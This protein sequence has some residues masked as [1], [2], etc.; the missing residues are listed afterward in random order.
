[1]VTID[2]SSARRGRKNRSSICTFAIIIVGLCLLVVP[3]LA[4]LLFVNDNIPS[5]SSSTKEHWKYIEPAS[6]TASHLRPKHLEA[7]ISSSTPD[8]YFNGFP[9]HLRKVDS[10]TFTSSH[11]HCI[12]ENF[13][14]DSWM[15]RSCQFTNLCYDIIEKDFVIFQ[16]Y[17]DMVLN[18]F[19]KSRPDLISSSSMYKHDREE[20]ISNID[21]SSSL[22]RNN[23]NT[24]PS[25]TTSVSLG[26]I[27]IKWSLNVKKQPSSGSQQMKWFPRIIQLPNEEEENNEKEGI[28]YY[29]LPS[30]VVMIPYHSLAG[31]NPGHLIWDDFLPLY[32]LLTMFQLQN[33]DLLLLRVLLPEK[34]WSSC[35]A[36]DKNEHMCQK[37]IHKFLPLL[38]GKQ[39]PYN[40]TTTN[41]V[42]FVLAQQQ[43][44]PQSNYIC[45]PK[46]AAGLAPLTDHGIH[47]AH[48]WM[49]KDYERTHNHGRGP[50]LYEFRNFML[51][52]IGIIDTTT[53]LANP[54]PP[55]KIVF[56]L[57]SS[58][59]PSRVLDFEKQI[60][61]LESNFPQELIEIE[62]YTM[63]DLSMEEQ[64]QLASKTSIFITICGGGAV[65]GM[66]LPKGA[67]VFLYYLA[68]GGV[69]HGVMTHLPAQLDW[70]LFNNL[71]Y[72]RVHWLPTATMDQTVDL[73][74]LVLLVRHELQLIQS[75]ALV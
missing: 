71:S 52:N 45:S 24:T 57:S 6:L 5:S 3:F 37:M 2:S 21:S 62:A 73:R 31:M 33:R 28:A 40:T 72:L 43:Q 59:I 46:G 42:Q 63:K 51:S 58:D 44:K 32:T 38:V 23:N 55:Y 30:N 64:M 7:E 35:E 69:E 26:G 50:M 48:G 4:F 13:H 12:G 25:T 9:L 75:Q 68:H 66:F 15:Q 41:N 16:S 22:N 54:N 49:R 39:Y 65:N 29:E 70:D 36:S 67:S 56:S 61:T 53:K 47:K 20:D 19:L 11:V 10:S 1:M 34:L 18:K 17:Q 14:D 8:A 74:A 27:N 60:Q